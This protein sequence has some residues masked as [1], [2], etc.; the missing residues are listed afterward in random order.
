MP[1]LS[2]PIILIFQKLMI[3]KADVTQSRLL[4]VV[5]AIRTLRADEHFVT[6]LR[7]EGLETMP[8]YL[9]QSMA[10]RSTS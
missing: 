3:K 6:L 1:I 10:A 8:S 7:A 2:T 5:E 9:E 4:F